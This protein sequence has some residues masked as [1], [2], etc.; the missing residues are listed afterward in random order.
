MLFKR[1]Q[2]YKYNRVE[3]YIWIETLEAM[4]FHNEHTNGINEHTS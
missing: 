3:I 4:E 1:A 2:K